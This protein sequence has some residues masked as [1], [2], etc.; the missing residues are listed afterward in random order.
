M[1]RTILQRQLP[2]ILFCL[3]ILVPLMFLGMMGLEMLR[4]ERQRLELE[5]TDANELIAERVIDEIQSGLVRVRDEIHFHLKS[6]ETPEQRRAALPALNDNHPLI[7]HVFECTTAGDLELP[8]QG[9]HLDE[10]TERFLKRFEGLFTRR[11]PW[12]PE[13]P[14][15]E[16]LPPLPLNDDQIHIFRT[17]NVTRQGTNDRDEFSGTASFDYSPSN[18]GLNSFVTSYTRQDGE[19]PSPLEGSTTES[20][21]DS[22]TESLPMPPDNFTWMPWHW[23]QQDSILAYMQDP[24]SGN[25]FG[26]ELEV[27]ALY[28]RLHVLLN[29]R[30]LKERRIAI[31][32]RHGHVLVSNGELPGEDSPE[33]KLPLGT[34][35]P[36]ADLVFYPDGHFA[37]TVQGDYDSLAFISLA[38][39]GL[40]VS[41][42]FGGFILG[43][44][45]QVTRRQGAQKTT[46]VSNV[47]HE[48]KTPLTTIRMYS[49]LLLDGRIKDEKKLHRYLT[50]MQREA[51]RLARL[52]HNVLDFS[53]LDHHGLALNKQHLDLRAEINRLST[54]LAERSQSAGM[55]VHF[56]SLSPPAPVTYDPDALAQILQNL[57]DNAAK[58]AAAGK[59]LTIDIAG[60][61]EFWCVRIM[62]RGPGIPRKMRK[63]IFKP[64]FQVNQ[65]L[66][67]KVSGTGLGL[68]IAWRLARE[69][70]GKLSVQERPDG[71]SGACFVW[72]LPRSSD[73]Q[74]TTITA[75]SV[76]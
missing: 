36:Y 69:S 51:D 43:Y 33:I 6:L 4:R 16:D 50:T 58:Y 20:S 26:L 62:D 38:G 31:I 17:S 3:F 60:K 45:L 67:D 10:D 64:F 68:S 40:S 12:F 9:V 15:G 53:R 70:G 61:D 23:E 47:S 11:I 46:F 66:T 32:D 7:R 37:P 76:P 1:I 19:S 44:W 39:I 55:T 28:D 24:R 57:C 75:I 35:M 22:L 42:L 54:V 2:L 74:Q 5:V 8:P 13:A 25:I 41:I 29:T 48:F 34:L 14:D 56:P 21:F 18:Q 49:E 73:S 65:G 52:V 63:Q 72:L 71:K 27:T 59:E 30:A